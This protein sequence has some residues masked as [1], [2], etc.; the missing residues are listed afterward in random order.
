MKI[1]VKHVL[2][3]ILYAA[4]VI[5]CNL[6]AQGVPLSLGLCF[7]MLACGTDII[8]VPVIY[9]LAAAVNLNLRLFLIALFSGAF[10]CIVTLLY[11]RAHKKLGFEG[12]VYLLITLS[13]Y[14]LFAPATFGDDLIENG[15]ILRAVCA[16][17]TLF[18]SYFCLKSVYALLYRAGRCR[19][20][21]EEFLCLA[22][23]YAVC[24]SGLYAALGK[25]FYL[26]FC[27]LFIVC[28]VRLTRSPA[29]VIAA[30]AAFIPP[31]LFNL[32]FNYLTTGVIISA[33]SLLF[34]SAGRF[35]T[36]GVCGALSALFI[37]L[38]GGFNCSKPMIALYAVLLFFACLIPSFITDKAYYDLKC[39]L[40]VTEVLPDTAVTR[41]RKQTGDRLYRISEVFREI[42][43]AFLALDEE[44]DDAAVRE[45][46]FGE[47][48]DKCCKGCERAK[49]CA[50]T[51]VYAG[52][53][54]LIDCGCIKGRV[55]LIDLPSDMTAEC[56]RP[57]DV[58]A[59][60]NAL[61]AE[62]RRCMTERENARS[63]RVLLAEQARGVAEVMKGC[64]V[65]LSRNGQ[66]KGAENELKNAL[67][68]HG[69]SCPELFIDGENAGE[70]CAVICGKADIKVILEVILKTLKRNYVLKDKYVYDG[71]KRCL[72]FGAKPALNAAFG[73][74]YAIKSG[75]KV[76]GDTHSVLRINERAFLMAL[77]DGMGSG[78]YARKV[79]EAAISLIEAFYRAEMPENTVLNTINKLLS[80]NRDERFTCIDIG[81]INLDTGR[82]DFIKIGSPAGIILREGEIKILESNSLPLG[83]L[84]NL[85]PTVCSEM[86]KSG[87][88]IVFMS[89]GI[90][91]AFD[92]A[93]DL[94]EFLQG[95]KPLNPQNL[96]DR[97]L[98]EALTKSGHKV[99]DDMTVL[100]TRLFEN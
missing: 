38:D 89:D 67:A 65:D 73:V 23:V 47:L 94:Y 46:M 91:S 1:N 93:T 81:A 20:K 100:C 28:A 60:L 34:S 33:I 52:F 8:A 35:A 49:R 7:A 22:I 3:Y 31:A 41:S 71:E 56:S 24:A 83:I 99:I 96:A 5:F 80:F 79:S 32:D 78:K 51:N 39:R 27:A 76:S 45:R 44:P 11:R 42:E 50:H 63:G 62:Y 72:I 84:D 77:S 69:I 66:F 88:I 64:A 9:A 12:V 14:I 17:V 48:K 36:G 75:E 59:E 30:L 6:A 16:A 86:L 87:D 13:P 70:I 54:R 85:R 29:A 57:A 43:C 61:L 15:Y 58:L 95:L 2:M 40:L 90:T 4:C 18:F 74:A 10:L 92:S 97:I 82:A 19:L 55:N 37:Y 26:C 21:D 68:T 53:K 98:A 25:T